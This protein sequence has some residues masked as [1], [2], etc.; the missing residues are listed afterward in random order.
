MK[1]AVGRTECSGMQIASQ[2]R[3][4][5]STYDV[6]DW[7]HHLAIQCASR[8]SLRANHRHHYSSI[9]VVQHAE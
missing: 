6:D 9:S 4:E 2:T 7:A 3:V 1:Y 8:T 5:I